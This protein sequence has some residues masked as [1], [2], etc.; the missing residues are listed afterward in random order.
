MDTDG[1]DGSTDAAGA[2][3]DCTQVEEKLH[4][5]SAQEF[6]NDNDSYNFYR[7]CGDGKYQIRSGSTG[8]DVHN[9][10]ILLVNLKLK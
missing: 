7:L 4:H 9:I 6:L 8:T 3:A 5:K 10:Q 1:K 2:F